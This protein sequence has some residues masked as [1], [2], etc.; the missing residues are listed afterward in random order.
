MKMNDKKES[1]TEDIH[2]FFFFNIYLIDR[3]SA[4]EISYSQYSFWW[5]T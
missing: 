1:H 2:S 5:L 4:K 3:I